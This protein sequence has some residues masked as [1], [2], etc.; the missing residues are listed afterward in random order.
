VRLAYNDDMEVRC[1]VAMCVGH[2]AEREYVALASGNATMVH[3][4][5]GSTS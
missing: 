4:M 3:A 5:N 2:C 1:M